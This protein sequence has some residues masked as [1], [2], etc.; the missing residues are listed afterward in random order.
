M[1]LYNKSILIYYTVNSRGENTEYRLLD[2]ANKNCLLT[3][4]MLYI[5]MYS[6]HG[7]NLKV[8]QMYVYHVAS[9]R[10]V[11]PGFLNL[12][13][14]QYWYRSIYKSM[15]VCQ[16]C[17]RNTPIFYHM[18]KVNCGERYI[19]NFFTC[20]IRK[21]RFVTFFKFYYIWKESP[22]GLQ[23]VL[24]HAVWCESALQPQIKGRFLQ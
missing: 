11:R 8:N 16:Y 5:L 21:V 20:P 23:F 15:F 7:G 1:N 4:N 19:Y 3:W 2:L 17:D 24:P 12:I 22:F 14:C 13:R 9:I 10:Y 6:M 18:E